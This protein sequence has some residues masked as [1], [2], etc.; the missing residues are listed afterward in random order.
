VSISWR[1]LLRLA[2]GLVFLW[3]ALA[4]IPEAGAFA[5]EVHYYRM[6]PVALE[7]L[8]ALGLVWAEL[9]IGLGLVLN[10]APRTMTAAAGFLLVVFFIAI[11]Q[12]VIRGLDIECGCFGTSDGSRVGLVALGRDIVFL[13]LAFFGYP[14]GGRSA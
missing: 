11:G 9:L 1:Y 4:K 5:K 8:F 6:L 2:L 3:A 14:R 7:N 10:L 12:A 13:A